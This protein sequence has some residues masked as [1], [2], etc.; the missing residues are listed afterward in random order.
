MYLAGLI[1]TLS[2]IVLNLSFDSVDGTL[3]CIN[4]GRT[5]YD[6]TECLHVKGTARHFI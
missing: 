3:R 1:K 4:Y 5:K 6:I 2:I